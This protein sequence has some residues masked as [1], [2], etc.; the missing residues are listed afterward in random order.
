MKNK[1]A[2]P[3]IDNIY[4]SQICVDPYPHF[5]V[6]NF[7]DE[8]FFS[9]VVTE[10][11]NLKEVKN[12]KMLKNDK[13]HVGDILTDIKDKELADTA[14]FTL[15]LKKF[16][17]SSKFFTAIANKI[18]PYAASSLQVDQ[19]EI[20]KSLDKKLFDSSINAIMP[21]KAVKRRGVH[22]DHPSVGIAFLLYVRFDDDYSSGGSLQLLSQENR[23]SIT[24]GKMFIGQ[25]LHVYPTDMTVIKSYEYM[26]NRLVVFSNSQHLLHEVS[27]RRHATLPRISFQGSLS[28]KNAKIETPSNISTKIK[29]IFS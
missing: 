20:S 10:L 28:V 24:S 21:G 27:T 16:L 8:D 12:I 26:N 19:L 17:S 25:M 1:Y 6:D 18:K 23:L 15:E 11:R 14:P 4:N 7:L 5:K 13:Y 29:S 3:A 22:L 2:K 9:K